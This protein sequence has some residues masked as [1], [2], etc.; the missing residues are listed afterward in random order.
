VN[1]SAT[2]PTGLTVSSVLSGTRVKKIAFIQNISEQ[3]FAYMHFSSYL[4]PHGFSCEVFLDNYEKDLIGA[5]KKY[6]PDILG[7]QCLTGNLHF[8]QPILAEY[9]KYNPKC[10][11]LV[12]GPH[13]TYIHSLVSEE[14][15]DALCVGESEGALLDICN[16]YDGTLDSIRHIPNV[17][18]FDGEKIINNPA[19]NVVDDLDTIPEPDR[20]LYDKYPYFE[21][22]NTVA[23]FCS[24]GCPFECTYC[25]AEG[26]KQMY[27]GKGNYAR[28]RG[29]ECII[30]EL[31]TIVSKYPNLTFL[32]FADSVI[33]GNPKWLTRFLKAYRENFDLPFF[34]HIRPDTTS[35][36]QIDELA[37][38]NCGHIAFGVEAGSYRLRKD[39]LKR[40]IT[41]EQMI[42][43]AKRIK[44]HGI[45]LCTANILGL[46]TETLEESYMLV[47]LNK[48]IQPDV[49]GI[50]L[51]QP[52]P[53]TEA[54]DFALDNKLMNPVNFDNIRNFYSYSVLVYQKD[55]K[56][57][58]RLHKVFFWLVRYP[59]LTPLWNCLMKYAPYNALYI[60]MLFGL[61]IS[62]KQQVGYSVVGI[63]KL[64]AGNFNMFA[65]TLFHKRTSF[66]GDLDLVDDNAIE[67]QIHTSG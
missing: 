13:P 40:N 39:V 8:G 9:K 4:K 50:S 56:V 51:W 37:A 22:L 58:E 31:K 49:L 61:T 23:I 14:G 53:G 44:A 63:V 45:K 34:C 54:T 27:K 67:R 38:A 7:F 60:L 19:R 62:Y 48:K 17:C 28:F 5:L 15:I 43:V 55:I 2:T 11:T 20:D 35:D 1:I 52:Y 25:Y 6:N 36:K 18:T 16:Q 59:K 12:G 66:S 47:E 64:I 3:L 41:D 30:N 29:P 46:P 65:K 42:S 10:L 32:N 33:N 26:L 57:Q 24:R 21:N